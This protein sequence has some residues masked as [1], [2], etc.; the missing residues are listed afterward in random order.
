MAGK[1]GRHIQKISN[2][3][4]K[5]PRIYALDPAGPG[6][7]DHPS[8]GFEPIKRTDADYVQIIHTNGGQLGMQQRTGT[9]DFYPNGGSKQ[10]G[11]N[12]KPGPNMIES[13]GTF[14]NHFR[15]WHF[16]QQSV[17]DNFA[18]PAIRCNSWDDF[19]SNGTCFKKDIVYMG[20][21]ADL[22]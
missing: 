19:M 2:G 4:V 11:C 7:E 8:I 21:G 12:I 5:I 22:T 6:F 3:L 14:C 16:Y 20:L 13:L 9:V 15:S 18:F 10:P 17:R 1:I